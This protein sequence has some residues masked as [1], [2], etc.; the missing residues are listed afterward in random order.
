MFAYSF[1]YKS[2]THLATPLELHDIVVIIHEEGFGLKA[3]ADKFGDMD[4][5]SI[6]PIPFLWEVGEAAGNRNAEM[7]ETGTNVSEYSR[8]FRQNIAEYYGLF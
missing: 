7:A 3:N 5:K 2:A 8:M 4:V 6:A 1:H